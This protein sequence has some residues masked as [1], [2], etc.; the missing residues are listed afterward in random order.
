MKYEER[1]YSFRKHIYWLHKKKAE[2][3]FVDFFV[4]VIKLY[5]WAFYFFMENIIIFTVVDIVLY[6]V[7]IVIK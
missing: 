5:W 7:E 4:A 3:I 6:S 1:V 2:I